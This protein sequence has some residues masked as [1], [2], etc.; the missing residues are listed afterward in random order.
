MGVT[1]SPM[2]IIPTLAALEATL[3]D[4]GMKVKAGSAVAAAMNVY[5][6]WGK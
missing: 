1:A 5:H 2:F 6:A 3:S 4:L